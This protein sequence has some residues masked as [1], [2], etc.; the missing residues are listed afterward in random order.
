MDIL[1][2]STEALTLSARAFFAPGML[3]LLYFPAEHTAAVYTPLFA[4]VAVPLVAAVVREG[5]LW[6]AE[7]RGAA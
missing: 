5:R 6:R 2:K 3:G 1:K 7:R 4:S